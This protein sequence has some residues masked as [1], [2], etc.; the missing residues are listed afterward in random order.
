VV[1]KFHSDKA[2]AITTV[3]CWLH[4]FSSKKRLCPWKSLLL[5]TYFLAS[6][7]PEIKCSIRQWRSQPKNLGGAKKV[8]GAEMLDFRRIT[9]FCL[10]NRI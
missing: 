7:G 3:A 8:G 6:R 2:V 5:F 4:N 1:E 10:E 9:L